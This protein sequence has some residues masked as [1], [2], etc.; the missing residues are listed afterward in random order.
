[1]KIKSNTIVKNYQGKWVSGSYRKLDGSRRLFHGK[2]LTDK[3]SDTCITYLDLTKKGIRRISLN[4]LQDLN[5][6][7]GTSHF[8]LGG[9]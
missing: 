1:M 9:R 8:N 7:C 2:L 5:I 6:S 4:K 3:R